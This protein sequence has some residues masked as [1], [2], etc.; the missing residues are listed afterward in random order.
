M[1]EAGVAPGGGAGLGDVGPGGGAGLVEAPGL[2]VLDK[3]C[4]WSSDGGLGK[5][6]YPFLIETT[7]L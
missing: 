1:E 4:F 3:A 2:F 6:K 7:N 5:T